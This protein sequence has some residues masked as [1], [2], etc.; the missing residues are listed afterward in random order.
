M[1]TSEETLKEQGSESAINELEQFKR[2]NQNRFSM[3][4]YFAVFQRENPGFDVV[5]C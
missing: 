5:R 2:T 3:E 1:G 4:L